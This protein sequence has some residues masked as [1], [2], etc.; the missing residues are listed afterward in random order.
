VGW[1]EQLHGKT[2]CVD[3]SPLI[4]FIEEHPIFGPVVDP[5][6]EAVSQGKLKLV[7]S[8]VALLEVLVHPLLR[9]HSVVEF[10]RL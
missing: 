5:F 6:F 8:T 10:S 3:T 1:V 2:V 7:I 9:L 4:F